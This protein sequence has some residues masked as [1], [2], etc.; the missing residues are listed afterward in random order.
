MNMCT[1]ISYASVGGIRK[2]VVQ[3]PSVHSILVGYWVVGQVRTTI[4]S[5]MYK[6]KF[7]IGDMILR[8]VLMI[9]CEMLLWTT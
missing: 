1:P 3:I 6:S 2:F 4:I 9:P 7:S 8:R 5:V